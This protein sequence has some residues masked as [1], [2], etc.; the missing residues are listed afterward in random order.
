[1]KRTHLPHSNDFGR[2]AGS[3]LLLVSLLAGPGLAAPS[4]AAEPPSPTV[5][6]PTSATTSTPTPTPTP[7]AT[8][9]AT[10]TPTAMATATATGQA[11]TLPAPAPSPTTT[12]PTPTSSPRTGTPDRAAMAAAIGAGGAEMGQR[13]ARVTGTAAA[14]PGTTGKTLT[15]EALAT[16]G[17]WKPTF[18]IQGLDVSGHQASVDWQPAVGHGGTFRLCQGNRRQLLLKRDLRLPVSRFPQCWDGPRRLPLRDSQLVLRGRPS[19]LLR[20]EWWRMECGRL[21]TATGTRF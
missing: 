9:D 21:H 4:T 5:A 20:Q 6:T 10:P 1:M 2:R 7:V 19:T 8:A 13:S 12:A 11:T 17:T 18:G 15:T 14:G 16:E 3:A